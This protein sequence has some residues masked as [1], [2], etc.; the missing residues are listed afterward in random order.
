MSGVSILLFWYRNE[1]YAIEARRA[2]LCVR[3]VALQDSPWLAVLTRHRQPWRNRH[4][5]AYTNTAPVL[6][7]PT[8][9]AATS[10]MALLVQLE[11]IL[12]PAHADALLHELVSTPHRRRRSPAEGAYSEGFIAS[13]FTQDFC[14]ECPAT[15]SLFSL[16]TGE[17]VTW[18]GSSPSCEHRRLSGAPRL[19]TLPIPVARQVPQQPGAAAADAEGH[20]PEPANLSGQADPGALH[21]G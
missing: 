2:M 7:K 12:H 5:D 14:I 17:I 20:V 11:V 3:S 15:S 19:L 10:C 13:K 8:Q 1:I 9:G 6:G 18:C 4:L 21:T 16:K